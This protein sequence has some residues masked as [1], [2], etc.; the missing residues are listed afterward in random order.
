MN[1]LKYILLL[2][3]GGCFSANSHAQS[4]VAKNV[5]I[6]YLIHKRDTSII[7]V[8][9]GEYGTDSYK[10]WDSVHVTAHIIFH[11]FPTTYNPY[12]LNIQ[13]KLIMQAEK[14]DQADLWRDSSTIW[15][16]PISYR[17][18]EMREEERRAY[19]G[20]ILSVKKDVRFTKLIDE[21]TFSLSTKVPKIGSVY[22][23]QPKI[24]FELGK[25]TL[26]QKS[27]AQLDSIVAFLKKNKELVLEIG[28][29]LDLRHSIHS[30]TRLD[31][32]RSESIKKYLVLKGVNAERLTVKGYADSV[33]LIPQE[34]INKLISPKE[35]EEAFA[36]S[37][38]TEFKIV[39]IKGP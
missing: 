35:K 7:H 36:V 37:R 5:S 6:D 26:L 33:P 38:R 18:K 19:I 16:Q 1:Q 10:S 32:K 30:S 27:C 29:H 39:Q 11:K 9:S 8:V 23:A 17:S 13:T 21:D 24:M 4:E 14:I 2:F 25:W 3:L 31:L 34:L 28:T 20:S 22:I 12:L 15:F